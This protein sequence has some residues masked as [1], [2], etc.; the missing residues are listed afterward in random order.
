MTPSP[1]YPLHRPELLDR[2]R[3]GDALLV[4][5]MPETKAFG[6]GEHVI[7]AEERSE[8]VYRL[9]TGWLCR[10]RTLP[11][12]RR[13][14]IAIFLPGDLCGVRSMLLNPQPEGLQCLTPATVSLIEQSRLAELVRMNGSVALRVMWQLS[15]DERRLH[16]SVIGLGRGNADE[17]IASMLVDLRERLGQL[18][19]ATD[20]GFRLPLTQQQIGDYLGLTVVHVNRVLRR[21]RESGVV[22]LAGK[23]VTIHDWAALESIANP[24]L[25]VFERRAARRRTARA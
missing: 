20:D 6:A 24:V 22:S 13:Q 21:L 16:N 11:D 3:E 9:Q 23:A 2:L 7:A 25:D 10:T 1:G 18:G 12:G 8:T 14:I 15:E 4:R 19:L 17:R 5:T